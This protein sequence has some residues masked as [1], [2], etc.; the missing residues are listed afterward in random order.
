MQARDGLSK[1]KKSFNVPQGFTDL[2]CLC[3]C[4]N[5]LFRPLDIPLVLA[6]SLTPDK[7]MSKT[8]A[9]STRYWK[10]LISFPGPC[11]LP[12]KDTVGMQGLVVTPGLVREKF[13]RGTPPQDSGLPAALKQKVE[14]LS[15][16]RAETRLLHGQTMHFGVCTKVI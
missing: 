2:V 5:E 1:G 7:V 15:L 3:L 10:L 8:T 12:R 13:K 6:D 4:R 16:Y 9:G 11:D 14:L